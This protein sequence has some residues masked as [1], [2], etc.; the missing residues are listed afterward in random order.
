MLKIINYSCSSSANSVIHTF[1]AISFTTL[2]TNALSHDTKASANC[3]FFLADINLY[4]G[5]VNI[6]SI[7]FAKDAQ[8]TPHIA[9]HGIH[10]TS[11]QAEAPAQVQ[12]CLLKVDA[13]VSSPPHSACPA[14]LLNVPSNNSSRFL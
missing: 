5:E 14:V 8:T 3:A 4:L 9:A 1:L 6:L 11:P 7:L 12:T 2:V 13:L 10:Q